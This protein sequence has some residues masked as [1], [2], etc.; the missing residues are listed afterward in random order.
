[1]D[2]FQPRGMARSSIAT[3]Q[4]SSSTIDRRPLHPAFNLRP[5]TFDVPRLSFPEPHG[6][7]STVH[8]TSRWAEFAELSALFFVQAAAMGAWF[9]PLGPVLDAHGFQSIKPLA[10]AASA[11]AAFISP[12]L[13]GAMA[14]RHVAPVLVL[15][16]LAIATAAAM[17][18]AA[19][20][21]GARAS[22]WV[23]LACIQLHALCSAPTWGISSAI[24]LKRL[25]NPQR[26]F[27]PVRAL[28]SLG[29]MVGC[30]VVSGLAADT[31][32]LACYAAAGIWL[33]VA[34]L[35]LW[36]PNIPPPPATGPL[37]IGQR[38]G[39][40][41]LVLLKNRD[42]RVVFLTTALFSI[43]L[44][45][46]Y[47]YTPTHL[48]SLG[49]ER[50]S[51]WMTLGQTTEIVAMIGLA[52]V[53]GR[54][55]LKWTF[56]AGLSIGLLRYAL[57]AMDTRAGVLTGVMLHGFSF[58]LVFITAQIYLDQRIDPAWRVRAQALFSV[59]TGGIGNLIGYLGTGWWFWSSQRAGASHWS[60]FWGGLAAI[61][62]MVTVFFLS[63]Y[64]GA[65]AKAR[66]DA[67]HPSLAAAR[68]D[69]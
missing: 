35:T 53:M 57:C 45:A 62:G 66:A 29:W 21:I 26:Q 2:G 49:L 60:L 17:V 19:L 67:R 18:L 13:F 37:T 33:L 11:V 42:H 65:G 20:A 46:F 6:L 27:G 32:T 40:D 5:S 64:R 63:T 14:D 56:A 15:R 54:F 48:Q 39:W 43:P 69:S 41:A 4:A 16:G 61:I 59:M 12:L 68:D 50:T 23:V 58:T 28:G 9:V 36:L 8:Q 47:P 38:L 24:V 7:V 51:A 22:A 3:L 34:V 30:W 44:A 10:F 55:R 25:S 52:A 1:M 31:S